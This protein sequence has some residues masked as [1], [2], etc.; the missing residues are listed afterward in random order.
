MPASAACHR[1]VEDEDGSRPVGDGLGEDDCTLRFHVSHTLVPIAIVN[2]FKTSHFHSFLLLV[3]VKKSD[4]FEIV[5]SYLFETGRSVNGT[6]DKDCQ[7]KKCF[8]MGK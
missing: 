8:R 6:M 3:P 7:N 1:I 4:K 5:L 2:R